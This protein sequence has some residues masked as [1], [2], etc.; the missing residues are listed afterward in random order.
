MID[1]HVI[2][3]LPAFALG[4]I[5]PPD[6]Q[7]V[8]DHLRYCETC[9]EELDAYQRAVDLLAHMSPPMNPP[10]DLKKKILADVRREAQKSAL[11]ESGV[12]RGWLKTHQQQLSVAWVA[13]SVVII[14]VLGAGSLFLWGQL[15]DARRLISPDFQTISLAGTENAS[16]ASAVIVVPKG[17][18]VGT[19]VVN[20]LPALDETQQYQLWLIQGDQR[21][22]GK[23]FSVQEDGYSVI[24]L[25]L[26]EK[27]ETYQDFGITIEPAG[28]SPAPTGKRVL[29]G[30]LNPK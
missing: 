19:L 15:Q 10:V 6:R 29:F 30:S 11:S 26:P 28:G 14:L 25:H 7:K 18:V 4:A 21:T 22:S 3:D 12:Q 2:D 9:R 27:I 23:V 5:D 16:G 17:D 1:H 24:Y 13:F 20:K 8:I